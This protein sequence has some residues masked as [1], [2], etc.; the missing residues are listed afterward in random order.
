MTGT[1]RATG[2]DMTEQAVRRESR[3]EHEPKMCLCCGAAY[4]QFQWALLPLVGVVDYR[5]EEE[6]EAPVLSL[7]NCLGFNWKR[8]RYCG[9]TLAVEVRR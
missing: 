7:R 2:Q 8:E 6:P 1:E 5:C 3:I 4:S 9:S